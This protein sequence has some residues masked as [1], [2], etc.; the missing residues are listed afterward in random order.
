MSHCSLQVNP[1]KDGASDCSLTPT[2]LFCVTVVPDRTQNSM[3]STSFL[4]KHKEFETCTF[5]GFI[6]RSN[7]PSNSHSLL[8]AWGHDSCTSSNPWPLGAATLRIEYDKMLK[9]KMA[10]GSVVS[11]QKC[12][13]ISRIESRI[14]ELE[15]PAEAAGSSVSLHQPK[16]QAQVP[17]TFQGLNSP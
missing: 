4:G 17:T 12:V 11:E 2:K 5:A 14:Y 1:R 9:H 15:H 13:R 16:H 10:A 7:G 6:M 3:L 8:Y